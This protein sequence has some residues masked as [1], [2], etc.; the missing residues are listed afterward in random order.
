MR[1]RGKTVEGKSDRK[2]RKVNTIIYKMAKVM[3]SPAVYDFTDLRPASRALTIRPR[4]KSSCA[5]QRSQSR[6]S[7]RTESELDIS[8][9]SQ[10]SPHGVFVVSPRKREVSVISMS[11]FGK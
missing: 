1:D 8:P 7:S 2:S 10:V 3:V 4:P 9:R 6:N 5:S 11:S